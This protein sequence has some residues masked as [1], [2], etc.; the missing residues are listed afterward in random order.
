[1][2]WIDNTCGRCGEADAAV[3]CK[4]CDYQMQTT[5]KIGLH[6]AMPRLW[7]AISE[8][9][10][11]R[12]LAIEGL[13]QRRSWTRGI[14]SGVARATR[15][16]YERR[17]VPGGAFRVLDY[18][19]GSGAFLSSL[20][21]LKGVWD[22]WHGHHVLEHGADSLPLLRRL[23]ACLAP[24]EAIWISTPNAE[25]FLLLAFQGAAR[26]VDFPRHKIVFSRKGLGSLVESA[27]LN[28]RFCQAPRVNAMQYAAMTLGLL[29]R[30]PGSA[31]RLSRAGVGA[32]CI[33]DA[34]SFSWRG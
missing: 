4:I 25:S 12:R 19:C 33:R 6:P 17:N 11:R 31:E 5:S 29:R 3:L 21:K 27:G 34:C 18:G 2:N 32:S 13:C 24:G 10:S 22:L 1:M 14:L 15:G 30:R 8:R 28:P 23:R 20:A 26:D 16:A 9:V 7:F